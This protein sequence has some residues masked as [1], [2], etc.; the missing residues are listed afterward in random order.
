MS[1]YVRV[2]FC[3][4]VTFY[5][6]YALVKDVFYERIRCLVRREEV[7]PSFHFSSPPTLC[8]FAGK[9]CYQAFIFMPPGYVRHLA[10]TR[11]DFELDPPLIKAFSSRCISLLEE[12]KG[13]LEGNRQSDV[14][15]GASTSRQN[16]SESEEQP[17]TLTSSMSVSA[18]EPQS[19]R[20]LQN[21]R[22]LFSPYAASCRNNWSC[23]P[24]AKSPKKEYSKLKRHGP[25]NF[26]AWP[27]N[28]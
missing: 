18:S 23:P 25:M 11:S 2:F 1:K 8:W 14:T 22:S 12:V 17:T 19:S 4:F 9:K 28:V 27:K 5:L 21:F 20:V 13:L 26:F 10:M 3:I 6:K 24:L 7:L 16:S 15:V